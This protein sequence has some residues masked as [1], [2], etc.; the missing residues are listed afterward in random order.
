MKDSV[1]HF[2][3]FKGVAVCVCMYVFMVMCSCTLLLITV[4]SHHDDGGAG[5]HKALFSLSVQYCSGT[6]IVLGFYD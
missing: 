5:V 2:I 3:L 1:D 4:S 6:A